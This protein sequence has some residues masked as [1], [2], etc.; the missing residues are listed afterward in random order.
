MT[1]NYVCERFIKGRPIKGAYMGVE[2]IDG[3][4]ILYHR[5]SGSNKGPIAEIVDRKDN[6]DL[7]LILHPHVNYGKTSHNNRIWGVLVALAGEERRDMRYTSFVRYD[8]IVY[9]RKLNVEYHL[10]E[11]PLKLKYRGGKLFIDYA[12]LES[13]ATPKEEQVVVAAEPNSNNNIKTEMGRLD[14]ILATV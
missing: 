14:T 12:E 3:R 10:T 8:V 11:R 7:T 9:D 13:H 5:W 2:N 1:I 6:G 4:E